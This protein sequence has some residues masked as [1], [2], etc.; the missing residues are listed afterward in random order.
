MFEY[1]EGTL[2]AK[3]PTHAVVDV[4]GAGYRVFIPMSTYDRLPD[5]GTKVR[6]L[7]HHHVREDAQ[8]LFG[9]ST[10]G[11]RALF[12]LLIN[13]SGIGPR[14]A[15]AA[16]SSM[17]PHDLKVH[18][19][20]RDAPMLQRIN[21]VGRKTA[22]RLVVELYDRVEALELEEAG[23]TL[24][25]MRSDALAALETLGYSRARAELLLRKVARMHPE[26]DSADELVRLA[27][28]Q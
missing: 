17:T 13:V 18:V 20:N 9:F 4:H 24:P 14:I 15:V 25:A 27:L 7:V 16:L 21:G 22:E 11:E 26:A 8:Q 5:P 19:T 2:Q 28:R 3:K 6:L 1:L 23:Q 10:H 12:E